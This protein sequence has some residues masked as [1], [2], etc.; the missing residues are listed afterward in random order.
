[1]GLSSSRRAAAPATLLV[2]SLALAGL[3]GGAVRPAVAESGAVLV[4][5]GDIDG[6]QDGEDTAE[7]VAKISG[8]LA[9]VGDNGY[10]EADDRAPPHGPDRR[11][12][13]VVA[14]ALMLADAAAI[15]ALR[16]RLQA[17]V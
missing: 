4:A 17:K 2:A 14:L 8:P 1:V 3:G 12:V 16:R 6:C 15:A 7:L 11:A 9:T 5:V 10:P 13:T